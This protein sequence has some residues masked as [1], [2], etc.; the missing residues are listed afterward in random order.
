MPDFW[1]LLE[2]TSWTEGH[3]PGLVPRNTHQVWWQNPS[4][5]SWKQFLKLRKPP[6]TFLEEFEA[7]CLAKRKVF[8]PVP[9]TIQLLTGSL[10]L[11]L[12]DAGSCC[13][14]AQKFGERQERLRLCEEPQVQAVNLT[15]GLRGSRS[16]VLPEGFCDERVPSVGKDFM[17]DAGH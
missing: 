1:S 3:L 9:Q 13:A 16:S 14:W 17:G 2:Y 10:Q 8:S 7:W 15:Q 6:L 4:K 5:L 11:H 12:V